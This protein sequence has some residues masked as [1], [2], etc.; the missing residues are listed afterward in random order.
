MSDTATAG[1]VTG[2]MIQHPEPEEGRVWLGC[3][4]C[5]VAVTDVRDPQADVE[6]LEPREHVVL[7]GG[8]PTVHSVSGKRFP[9]A[10]C[11]TC[12]ARRE[13]AGELLDRHPLLRGRIG[14]RSVGVDRVDAALMAL[15]ALG[16]SDDLATGRDVVLALRN[17]T[18]AANSATW[19]ARYA[20]LLKLDAG[21]NQTAAERWSFLDGEQTT[22]LREAYGRFLRARTFSAAMVPPPTSEDRHEAVRG[23]ML[24]GIGTVKIVERDQAR[25]I[26]GPMLSAPPSVLRGRPSPEPIYGY[27][28]PDCRAS[29]A[30]HGVQSLGLSAV[31]AALGDFLDVRVLDPWSEV[32]IDNQRLR[33]LHSL[34]AWAVTG[35]EP[36][37]T[38]WAH[39]EVDGSLDAVR[40]L[41]GQF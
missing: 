28:C 21:D 11:P 27:A 40:Q 14:S 6:W 3:R 2:G 20:P 15:D 9:V 31:D 30:R 25:A 22:T 17:L 36:N 33:F 39:L 18:G 41:L 35:R 29:M 12:A 37:A 19:G 16:A 24:C 23:C 7:V 38:P 10:T 34:R 26:W 13:R 1:I 5:G 4:F 32:G 8:H